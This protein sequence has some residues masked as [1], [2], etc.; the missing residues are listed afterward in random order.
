M[1]ETLQNTQQGDVP[2]HNALA[3]V[4]Q[5]ILDAHFPANCRAVNERLVNDPDTMDQG[6]ANLLYV[7]SGY[8]LLAARPGIEAAKLARLQGPGP[9]ERHV[10]GIIGELGR[11]LTGASV[12]IRN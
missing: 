4:L 7:F 2:A 11:R 3:T 8:Q 6:A 5:R 12:A 9:L 1:S 10:K